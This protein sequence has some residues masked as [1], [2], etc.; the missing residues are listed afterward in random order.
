MV[1]VVASYFYH[2]LLGHVDRAD[3]AWA[4]GVF[5]GTAVGQMNEKRDVE[6]HLLVA[7]HEVGE[8]I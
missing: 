6:V 8:E 4:T 7:L 1:P 2:V 5:L 3:H